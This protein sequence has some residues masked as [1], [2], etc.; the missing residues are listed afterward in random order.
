MAL[1]PAIRRVLG[2]RLARR[3][4]LWYRA[5]YVDLSA[6]AATLAAVLPRDAQVLDVGG[7]DGQPLNHLLDLRPDLMIT[8][9]DSAPIVGQWIEE[10]FAGRVTRLPATTLTEYVS[11]GLKDP[12]ALLIADVMHHIHQT[13][14]R[15]FLDSVRVLLDRVPN[16][17]IIVK[18]VEPGYWR[19]M[20]GYWS[21]RYVTGD[22]NVSLISSHAVTSLFEEALGPL[23]CEETSLFKMDSPNYALVFYR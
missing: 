14:R 19:A 20:L 12:D 15:G 3:V 8:T 6:V 9:L 13:A 2:P 23:H 22:R 5:I 4:G 16:L 21:D 11:R 17:R 10:R 7:G 18:D 1:G